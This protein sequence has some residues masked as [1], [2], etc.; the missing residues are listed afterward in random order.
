MTGK[1]GARPEAGFVGVAEPW[2]L[3]NKRIMGSS[4]GVRSI[5][6][7]RDL[8]TIK[9]RLNALEARAAEESTLLTEDQM[10]VLQKIRQTK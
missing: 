1:S 6:L 4:P 5:R 10:A 9:K 2:E 8:E 7:R 3:R